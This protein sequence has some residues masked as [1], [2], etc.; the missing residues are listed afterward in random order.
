[1]FVQIHMLQSVPPGNLNRDDSGQPKKCIFGG[2]TRGRISSQCLKRNIRLSP[3]FKE[4][5][6]EHLAVRSK[7]LPRLVADAL[8][9]MQKTDIPESEIESIKAGLAACFKKE[10]KAKDDGQEDSGDEAGVGET[11]SGTEM[12]PQL[13][14]FKPAFAVKIASLINE[15]RT[16]N[17]L[18]Y[19]AF[20]GSKSKKSEKPTKEEEKAAKIGVDK[21]KRAAFDAKESLSVDVALFGR[22]TTSD[23]IADVEAACQVAHALSTHETLIE[24]DYFTAMDDL[25]DNFATTQSMSAGAA[26]L[27]SGDTETFFNS[28]VYYK[29]FNLDTDGML[30]NL[31]D[32]DVGKVAKAAGVFIESAALATPTGKQNSF[33]AHSVPELVLVEISKRKQPISYANAFLRPIQADD[34]MLASTE[35]L[36]EYCGSVAAAFAPPDTHRFLLVVGR[37]RNFHLPLQAQRVGTLAELAAEIEKAVQAAHAGVK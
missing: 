20:I 34:L 36:G 23:I 7:Y 19:K 22:M 37:A 18:A 8:K 29:Y 28:A 33:A 17:P 14:F 6:G 10:E 21:F 26:F 16:D 9:A 25:R 5:F 31:K 3:N 30:A 12:T 1:M 32:N 27:G 11:V 35:A 24:S 13:V 15:M 2:V 4:A